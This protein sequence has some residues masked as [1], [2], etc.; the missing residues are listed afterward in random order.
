[1]HPD[2]G[3]ELVEVRKARDVADLRDERRRGR[4]ADAGDGLESA[5]KVAIEQRGHARLGLAD[6]ALQQVVLDDEQ[7]HLEADLL[8]QLGRRDRLFGQRDDLA[9]LLLADRPAAAGP[10]GMSQR[11]GSLARCRPGRGCLA[12]HGQGAHAGRI[13]VR[14]LEL[15]EADLDEPGDAVA[16][17]RLLLDEAHCKARRL[18]QLGPG[19]R[20]AR[21]RL[22][23]HAQGCEGTRVGG[24][25]LGSL[26]APLG[27]VPCR[28]RV[29]HRDRQVRARERA[30]ERHPVVAARFHDHALDVALAREPGAQL[31]ESTAIA[32]KAK[33]RLLRDALAV[34]TDRGD[35]PALPDVDADDRHGRPPRCIWLSGSSPS[36]ATSA[37]H[38]SPAGVAAA[39]GSRSP[40]RHGARGPD[41][42]SSG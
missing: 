1:M 40:S 37:D 42:R 35:M 14:L 21:P 16:K 28:N 38:R 2:V 13:L 18:A 17:A 15:G 5:R 12:Q 34:T 11:L 27:E 9:G 22:V 7:L 30:G 6:L 8:G 31:E 10:L 19:K 25:A 26:E 24:I 3:D 32:A 39:A 20:L 23:R 4:G 41:T 33:H 29:H 36:P